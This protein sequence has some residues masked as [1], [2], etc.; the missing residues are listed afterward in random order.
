MING[1]SAWDQSAFLRVNRLQHNSHL[2]LTFRILSHSGDGYLY[3]LL[4][5][6][7]HLFE[8]ADSVQFLKSALLAFALE[9]PCFLALK[10]LIKRERPCEH[11]AGC[12]FA[13]T[14]SDKFSMPSGHTAAAFL[15]SSLIAGFYPAFTVL[16]YIWASLIGA[17]RVFLGV[18]YPT[19]VV[20]G[21]ALGWSCTALSVSLLS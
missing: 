10:A 4:G 13:V 15:M 21:A 17:S 20:A 16:A 3:V 12:S 9:I 8:S 18:H 19:D 1:V 6:S 14:P 5:I 2:I 7:L 11:L